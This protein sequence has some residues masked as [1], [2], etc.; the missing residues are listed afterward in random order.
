MFA[1]LLFPATLEGKG[2]FPF[3][4]KGTAGQPTTQP[5]N[6]ISGVSI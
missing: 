6:G 4:N 3:P 2:S 1:P 5:V